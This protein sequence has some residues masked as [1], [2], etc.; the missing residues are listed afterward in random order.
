[1]GRKSHSQAKRSTDQKQDKAI[2][3][4]TKKVKDLEKPIERKFYDIVYEGSAMTAGTADLFAINSVPVVRYDGTT[5]ANLKSQSAR[6][7]QSISMTKLRIRGQV[8]VPQTIDV[9]D[10]AVRVRMLVC[11]VKCSQSY[12]STTPGWTNFITPAKYSAT[13]NDDALVD[14]FKNPFPAYKYEILYDKTFWLQSTNQLVPVSG[15]PTLTPTGTSTEKF[16][17]PINVNIKLNSQASWAASPGSSMPQTNG[18]VCY[19]QTNIDGPIFLLNS[20]LN[21]LDE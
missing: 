3:K 7:G 11:R 19:F 2:K 1:M 5:A 9:N 6:L 15:V 18:L 16:R 8:Y 17:A 10:Q 13:F 4:L 12:T 21:Y 14:G 20:R